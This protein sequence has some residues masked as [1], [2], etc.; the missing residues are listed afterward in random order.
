MKPE[1][2]LWKPGEH[3]GTF[4]GN[5]HA[6]VT[7]RV[8]LNK[9][10]ADDRFEH[11]IQ[12]KAAKLTDLLSSYARDSSF[13]HRGFGPMQGLKLENSQFAAQVKSRFR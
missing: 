10:W 11:Q 7:A 2:D 8:A 6:F 9:F 3:N 13:E 5:N 1:F 4:R 12:L